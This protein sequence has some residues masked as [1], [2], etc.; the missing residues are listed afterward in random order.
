MLEFVRGDTEN[1]AIYFKNMSNEE[2]VPDFLDE[3]DIFTFTLARYGDDE[4]IMQKK[5]IYPTTIFEFSHEET[6]K[7][8]I[9][10]LKFDIEYSKP[11]KSKVKTLVIDN[12]KVIR[13]ITRSGNNG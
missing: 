13:D 10:V 7:L 5:I 2:Y 12:L 3:G 1:I 6:K 4:I 9:E 11:D 8:P